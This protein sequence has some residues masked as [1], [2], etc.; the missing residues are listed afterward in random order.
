VN[1]PLFESA[2]AVLREGSEY[3]LSGMTLTVNDIPMVLTDA[4]FDEVW[5]VLNEVEG[6]DWIVGMAEPTGEAG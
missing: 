2:L 4:E 6:D 3:T 1:D 5:D